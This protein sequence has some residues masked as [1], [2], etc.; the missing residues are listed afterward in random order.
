MIKISNLTY[1]LLKN[2]FKSRGSFISKST[3]GGGIRFKFNVIDFCYSNNEK[4]VK[5][6]VLDS[7]YDFFKKSKIDLILYLSGSLMGKKRYI[8]SSDFISSNSKNKEYILNNKE[9]IRRKL[10][11]FKVGDYIH[12]ISSINNVFKSSY[13]RAAGSYAVIINVSSKYL[14]V[15]MPSKKIKK[16]YYK[17]SACFGKVF[18]TNFDK[19]DLKKAGNSRHLGRRPIVRGV[20]MNAC[21][22]PH[23]G[24]EGKSSI[25][26]K[27]IFSFSKSIKKGSRTVF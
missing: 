11:N 1:F 4:D 16:L 6:I 21:D 22:H 26:R 10:L 23:G 13:I 8:I 17:L 20:W 14:I 2:N 25:G 5:F 15:R 24:G 9:G 19:Y 7:K 27:S 18:N 12:C 3:R